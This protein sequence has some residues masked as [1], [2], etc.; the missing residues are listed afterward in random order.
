MNRATY[1]G[2]PTTD[3]IPPDTND[4]S[5]LQT[6]SSRI[7]SRTIS[8]QLT[9]SE[10]KILDERG[11][12]DLSGRSRVEFCV[13]N[14]R[15]VGISEDETFVAFTDDE[16]ITTPISPSEHRDKFTDLYSENAAR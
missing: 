8:E 14:V 10:T 3:I 11:I 13:W 12:S 2:E 15:L 7:I 9:V 6:P 1:L 5:S 16:G 4:I